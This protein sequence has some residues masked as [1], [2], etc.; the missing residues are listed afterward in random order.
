M[1]KR[2]PIP[3]F[4][5]EFLFRSNFYF[6]EHPPTVLSDKPVDVV[7][8]TYTHYKVQITQLH[9][10]LHKYEVLSPLYTW[11]CH[12]G[13]SFA[14]N[15]NTN[16]A[17]STCKVHRPW[18]LFRATTVLDLGEDVCTECIYLHVWAWWVILTLSPKQK[19]I[20]TRGYTHLSMDARYPAWTRSVI[21]RLI[22][23]MVRYN[24]VVYNS[25]HKQLTSVRVSV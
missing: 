7:R 25:C 21:G 23:I 17:S 13:W 20:C 19:V 24:I 3:Q 16:V 15:C 2:L 10:S 1:Y 18:A 4:C 9:S 6:K 12:S 11:Q 14:Y 22:S 8:P 5:L